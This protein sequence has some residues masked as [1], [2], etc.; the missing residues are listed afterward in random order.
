MTILLGWDDDDEGVPMA[1][2]LDCCI[3]MVGVSVCGGGCDGESY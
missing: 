3:V 2:E 1:S